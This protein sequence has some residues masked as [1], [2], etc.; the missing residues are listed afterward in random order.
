MQELLLI[1]VNKRQ[2]HFASVRLLCCSWVTAAHFF[3]WQSCCY[4]DS[5]EQMTQNIIRFLVI[6]W[7]AE[8]YLWKHEKDRM[9]QSQRKKGCDN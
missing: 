2:I 6:Q 9:H 5:C 4:C 3:G 7:Q 1:M 8:E